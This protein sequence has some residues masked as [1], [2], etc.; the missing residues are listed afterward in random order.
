MRP[1]FNPRGGRNRLGIPQVSYPTPNVEDVIV[2][3]DVPLNDA[4][5]Q[6]VLIGTP[7]AKDSA[8]KLVWQAPIQGDG[9]EK[10]VRRIYA[11]TR[12]AQ[13]AYNAVL[14]YV[15]ESASHPIYIRTS[16]E[17]KENWTPS[18]RG[19]TLK[20]IVGLRVTA[21]GS[22]YSSPP[23]VVFTGGAGSGAAAVAEVQNGAV[24]ALLITDGGTGYTSAPTISF[25]GGGGGTGA[26]AAA[27]I[28]PTTAVL[29][30]EDPQPAEG[31]LGSL[32]FT[33]T[34]VY[35]TL[36]GPWLYSYAVEPETRLSIEQ[37]RRVVAATAVAP[38]QTLGSDTTREATENSNI[39]IEVVSTL[40]GGSTPSSRVERGFV[41]FTFP[42]LLFGIS[43]AALTGRDGEPILR[44]SYNQRL[45]FTQIVPK[46][47]VITYGAIGTLTPPAVFSPR[48]ADIVYDGLAFQVKM[49]NLL[50]D[51]FSLSYT[52]GSSN[53]KF[54]FFVETLTVSATTMTAT[55]YWALVTGGSEICI[56]APIKPWRF[57]HERME[58]TY[59]DAR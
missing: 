13:D 54:P 31:E 6:P 22:G 50:T 46:R 4:G 20:T 23:A 49:H 56:G 32:F 45:G 18:T 35:Q 48:L 43:G 36:P 19:S 52:S 59:I 12:S 15:A 47:T 34:R 33:V 24:V 57:G 25:T 2:V 21:G 55:E 51:A 37:K 58:A 3:E 9:N 10:V 11:T 26:T 1:D 5:Y 30:K 29:I 53:P 42:T 41:E 16:I 38:S 7:R 8:A 40:N 17:P 14:R 44:L 39:Q 28:Q 27:S